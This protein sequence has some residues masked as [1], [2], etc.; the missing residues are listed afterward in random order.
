MISLVDMRPARRRSAGTQQRRLPLRQERLAEIIDLAKNL[1][2]PIQHH[3]H[4]HSAM[5]AYLKKP[6]S[7]NPLI[8]RKPLIRVSYGSRRPEDRLGSAG[9]KVREE[10]ASLAGWQPRLL[11]AN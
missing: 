11:G 8:A 2:D 9:Q 4:R 10:K 7:H 5:T 3:R 1:D 6:F